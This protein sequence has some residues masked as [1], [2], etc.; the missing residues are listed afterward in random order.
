M[1]EQ[2]LSHNPGTE[3]LIRVF[4][5]PVL[6]SMAPADGGP[7]IRRVPMDRP[8]IWLQRGWRDMMT[9]PALSIGFGLAITAL[10]GLLTAIL[11]YADLHV[12]LLPAL[13]GFA[14]IAPF[15][16]CGLYEISRRLEARQPIDFLLAQDGL[17]RNRGSI[18]AMAALLMLLHLAWVRI[19]TLLFA[20]YYGT[21]SLT[22]NDLFSFAMDVSQSLPF[23][24]LGLISGGILAVVVFAL[25]AVSLPMLVDRPVNLPTALATSVVA[26]RENWPAMAL[27]AVIISLATLFCF[28]TLYLG[29]IILMPLIG[30][31]TWHAY[32]DLVVNPEQS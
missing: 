26:V 31:A 10:S 3:A 5:G 29:F 15:L 12:L 30:H 18:G 11:F 19:A 6:G 2:R 7:R 27:W 17:R 23:L 24:A 28:V 16:G 25:T 14:L 21:R 1:S 32:R 20:L 9:L 4:T 22:L 8:W 13:A